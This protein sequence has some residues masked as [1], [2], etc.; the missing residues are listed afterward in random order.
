[1]TRRDTGSVAGDSPPAPIRPPVLAA[2]ITL[3]LVMVGA[4]AACDPDGGDAGGPAPR[5]VP[6][7]AY[8]GVTTDTAV[9]TDE[10]DPRYFDVRLAAFDEQMRYLHDAGYETITPSEY[11]SW[12]RG[13]EISLPAKPMLITFDD[14]QTSAALATPVLERY[15]FQAVMYVVSGFADGSFGSP[16][17]EPGWYLTWDQLED[18]RAGGTWI[19]QFH[20]GP[21][22]HAFVDDPRDP[23]CHRFY[24]CAYGEDADTYRARVKSDVAQGLGAMRTAFGLPAGWQGSTFAVPWDAV[25]S[26]TAPDPWLPAYFAEQFP[27]VFVQESYTGPANHQR[28]RHE[29]HNPDAVAELRSAVASSRFTR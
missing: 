4:L 14:G 8:H 27:V 24:P 15:G 11:V 21:R 18:M 6:V 29:I 28:Y 2:L 19:M 13:D 17:G 23:T 3:V 10:S 1:V 22:G 5:Q 16:T 25:T 26:D 20:A 9:V 7:L 12:V